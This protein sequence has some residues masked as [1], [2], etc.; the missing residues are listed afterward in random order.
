LAN[1]YVN[2]VIRMY[3]ARYLPTPTTESSHAFVN[4]PSG[5]A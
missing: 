1:T 4:E 5:R 3:G 2:A